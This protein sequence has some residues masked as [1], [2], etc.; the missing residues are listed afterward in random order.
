MAS[1]ASDAGHGQKEI[2]EEII[3]TGDVDVIISIGTNFFYTR[4][5]SCT[6]WFFDPGKWP[7]RQDKV[8]MIDARSIY[9]PISRKIHDFSDEQLKNITAC[10]AYRGEQG[11]YLGL[12]REYF[13]RRILRLLKFL[14]RSRWCNR[15]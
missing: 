1:S 14:R 2:R 6:L 15:L 4:S 7:D 12:V 5:L 3:A 11:R 13:T 10:M 8:L 9:R